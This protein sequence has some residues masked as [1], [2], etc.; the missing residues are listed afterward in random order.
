[1]ITD[2]IEKQIHGFVEQCISK[3]GVETLAALRECVVLE[4]GL[5]SSMK[6][7]IT[8][9]KACDVIDDMSGRIRAGRSP[10]MITDMNEAMS[11]VVVAKLA[12]IVLQ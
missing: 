3:G 6:G 10:P 7:L 9:G 11:G 5:P 4:T 8:A 2:S 12:S 1:M